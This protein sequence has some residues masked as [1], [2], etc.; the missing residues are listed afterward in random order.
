VNKRR[1]IDEGH[2]S[3]GG[4]SPRPD[5]SLGVIEAGRTVLEAWIFL[6]KSAAE[7]DFFSPIAR[8]TCCRLLVES[9]SVPGPL[10][11]YWMD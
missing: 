9:F 11:S 1:W 4:R 2:L 8:R 3:S 10:R 5:S 6:A 7:N